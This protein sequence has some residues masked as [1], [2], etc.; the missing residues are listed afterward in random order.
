MVQANTSQ[1]E[2]QLEPTRVRGARRLLAPYHTHRDPAGIAGPGEGVR[3][4][5]AFDTKEAFGYNLRCA[6]RSKPIKICSFLPS[7]PP[8]ASGVVH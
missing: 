2:K 1:A 8:P 5:R 4:K 3:N 7:P 6:A